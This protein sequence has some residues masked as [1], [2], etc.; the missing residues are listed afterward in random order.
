MNRYGD[1][2]RPRGDHRDRHRVEKL[3]LGQPAVLHDRTTVEE[4]DHGQSAAEHDQR[5]LG[6]EPEHLGQSLG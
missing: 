2:Y 5:G 1:H 6:E 4:G 3:A